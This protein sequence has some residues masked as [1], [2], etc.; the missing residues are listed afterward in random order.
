MTI[1][2]AS[3]PD[4]QLHEPKGVVSAANKTVYVSTG[5]STGQWRRIT[6]SDISYLDK[7][8]N[9]YGWNDIADSQYTS[10]APLSISSGI[11][12]QLPNNALKAQTDQSRLGT[13]WASN[14]F[15]ISDLNAAYAL[16][17][18]LKCKAAA[19]AGTPYV[20]RLEIESA[21]GPT[22][23]TAN[24]AFIK[25]GSYENN[26]AFAPVFYTGSFINAQAL[27]LYVTPDTAVTIY[28][29]GFVIQRTYKES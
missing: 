21:N 16:R 7:T 29:I 23:I 19:A 10:G 28:D 14:Q 4:S 25:G 2:H 26:I 15:L 13:I 1:Q 3:I 17:I 9:I 24:E 6:D 11:R 8:K 20:L 27:K 12:T 18:N 22:V 5:T